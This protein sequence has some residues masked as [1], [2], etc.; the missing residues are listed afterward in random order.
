MQA[1]PD[2]ARGVLLAHGADPN[3]PRRKDGRTSLH[4]AA[5]TGIA[6]KLV[7]QLADADAGADL[8]ARDAKRPTA[9]RVIEELEGER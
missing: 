1:R 4:L 7:R 2:V 9:A 6:G 3:R 8:G 5:A